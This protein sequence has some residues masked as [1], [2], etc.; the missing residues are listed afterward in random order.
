[1]AEVMGDQAGL[2]RQDGFGVRP[3]DVV[4]TPNSQPAC[5]CRQHTSIYQSSKC[6]TD[7]IVAYL[8]NGT[9]SEALRCLV[10]SLAD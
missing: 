1:M 6:V 5:C 9:V 4:A 7:I 3:C 2:V 10:N 8:A